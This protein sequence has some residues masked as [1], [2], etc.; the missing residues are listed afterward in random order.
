MRRELSLLTL[1]LCACG[2]ASSSGDDAATNFTTGDAGTLVGT[3]NVIH[4]VSEY[5]DS[6]S[7]AGKVYNGPTPQAV[8]W[9]IALTDGDCRVET[10]HTPFCTTSCGSSAACGPSPFPGSRHAAATKTARRVRP[11]RTISNANDERDACGSDVFA[12]GVRCDAH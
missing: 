5:G 8:Q 11:A 3:F 2:G 7:F 4:T 9:T 1:A 6:S 12:R 10:P